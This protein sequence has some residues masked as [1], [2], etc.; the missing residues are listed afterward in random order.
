[1]ATTFGQWPGETKAERT[2]WRA[3]ARSS[4]IAMQYTDADP[5]GGPEAERLGDVLEDATNLWLDLE[6]RVFPD[7]LPNTDETKAVVK[8]TS[9]VAYE[10]GARLLGWA[11]GGR[12]DDNG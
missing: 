4:R 9:D 6:D 1:M 3:M 11:A 5:I 12:V 10:Q 7:G 8:L 2:M